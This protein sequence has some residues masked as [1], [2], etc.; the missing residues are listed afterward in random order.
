MKMP[1]EK[2]ALKI[3]N[4]E[5]CLLVLKCLFRA[6]GKKKKW[7]DYGYLKDTVLATRDDTVKVYDA[8][9]E[10]P[11][12]VRV[13]R[14][15]KESPRK[16][17]KATTG[18]YFAEAQRLR[19]ETQLNRAIKRL[20]D[21]DLVE[22]RERESKRKQ[23]RRYE[24]RVGE[25]GAKLY[26]KMDH[27]DRILKFPATNTCIWSDEI[28]SYSSTL[29]GLRDAASPSIPD[30]YRDAKEMLEE[31]IRNFKDLWRWRYEMSVGREKDHSGEE[32]EPRIIVVLD[33]NP[34]TQAN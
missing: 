31:A 12:I 10:K 6:K 26:L 15:S 3:V 20:V 18:D 13:N 25:E 4:E 11:D 30:N 23:K 14:S 9:S 16:I 21:W 5:G 19:S 32:G 8:L 22:R 2:E 24:Y 17:P 7:V 1:D 28:I 29:T 27:A 34:M 33:F